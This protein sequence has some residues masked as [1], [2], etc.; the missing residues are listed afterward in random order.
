MRYDS[1]MSTKAWNREGAKNAKKVNNKTPIALIQILQYF[2]RDL[3]A[4]AVKYFSYVTNDL[5]SYKK[6]IIVKYVRFL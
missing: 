4:F 2:L 3:C 1:S 6:G 5:S